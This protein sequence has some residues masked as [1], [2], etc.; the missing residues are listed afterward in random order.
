MNHIQR[1]QKLFKIDARNFILLTVSI[2]NSVW[3]FGFCVCVFSSFIFFYSRFLTNSSF[4]VI[5]RR[6]SSE[7]LCFPDS[8]VS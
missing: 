7:S 8:L 1:S 5:I 3:M 4:N 6:S 2:E